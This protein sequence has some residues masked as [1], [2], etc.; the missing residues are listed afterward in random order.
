MVGRA[1]LVCLSVSGIGLKISLELGRFLA[2]SHNV[3]DTSDDISPSREVWTGQGSVLGCGES[4]CTR[5]SRRFS[6]RFGDLTFPGEA[7]LFS[8]APHK[9]ELQTLAATGVLPVR[10]AA[11]VPGEERGSSVG[12]DWAGE[13]HSEHTAAESLLEEDLGVLSCHCCSKALCMAF[14]GS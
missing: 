14:A 4:A 3:E 1:V 9:P 10:L 12:L 11:W 5:V 13:L 8:A 2:R 6:P 7:V